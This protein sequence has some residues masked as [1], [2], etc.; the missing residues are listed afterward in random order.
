MLTVGIIAASAAGA[1]VILGAGWWRRA[2]A[3]AGIPKN[4][5]NVVRLGLNVRRPA[6]IERVNAILGAF[7]DGFNSMISAPQAAAWRAQ[8]DEMSPVLQPFAHEGAAMGHIPRRLMRYDAARFEREFPL[9]L[10]QFRYL[11]YVGLGFWAGMRNYTASK[12]ERLVRGLDPLYAYLVYD[13][14]GFKHAFFDLP[15]RADGLAALGALNGYARAA[16]YQGVGRAMWFYHMDDIDGLASRLRS[17]GAYG[18]HAAAGVGLAAVFTFPDDLAAAL[19]SLAALPA[20]WHPALSLGMCFGSKARATTDRG[21]FTAEVRALP[22]E[23]AEAISASIDACDQLE[24]QVRCDGAPDGY[25]RWRAAVTAWMEGNVV[26]PMAALT[27]SGSWSIPAAY[28]AASAS[29]VQS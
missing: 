24:E 27:P 15:K 14:Y 17:F 12:L 7:A 16:A 26:F 25:A 5:M 19:E 3:V 8:A 2:F 20:E 1:G 4:Q 23:R 18:S 28:A 13:G 9:R 10:P 22:V 11:Y 29:G 6:R 21:L